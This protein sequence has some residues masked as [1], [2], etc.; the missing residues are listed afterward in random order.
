[1]RT[2]ETAERFTTKSTKDAKGDRVGGLLSVKSVSSVVKDGSQR[3]TTEDSETTVREQRSEN[4][5]DAI[6]QCT[7][8]A[9]RMDQQ[10]GGS[11]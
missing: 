11:G 5:V 4:E 10:H 3:F 9:G 8:V 7:G 2:R 6:R 1:M